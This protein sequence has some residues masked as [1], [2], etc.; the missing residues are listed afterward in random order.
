MPNTV[1]VKGF[2]HPAERN[3]V[4]SPCHPIL[5]WQRCGQSQRTAVATAERQRVIFKAME[6]PSSS[7]PGSRRLPAINSTERATKGVS[8]NISDTGLIWG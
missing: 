7:D 8:L 4:I 5:T 6:H 1:S 3:Y 2:E